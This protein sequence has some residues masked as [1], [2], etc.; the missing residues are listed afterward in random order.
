M[1]RWQVADASGDTTLLRRMVR[2]V[3]RRCGS[4]PSDG[5][6]TNDKDTLRVLKEATVIEFLD[7][8]EK[9]SV[10]FPAH[11]HLVGAAKVAALQRDR[12][13]S[14]G[15]LLSDYDW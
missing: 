4:T 7:E 11:R 6:N 15:M 3:R 12:N 9:T 8:F 2:G 14:P 5:S 10:K 1:R 13:F